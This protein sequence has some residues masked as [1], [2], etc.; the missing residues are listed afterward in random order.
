MN[1]NAIQEI[2]DRQ[3]ITDGLHWYTR[4]V[5]LNRVD[6]QVQIFTE[7][8][9]ITFYGED[10]WTVGRDNIEAM[11]VPAVAKYTATH[12][13]ISNIEIDFEGPN[14][15]RSVCYLQAWHRPAD[16]SE[17]YTLRAQYHDK[18]S[19]TPVGWRLSERRLKAAGVS[20]RG[21]GPN[22]ESIGRES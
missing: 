6:K 12:H 20:N 17:D 18:W 8:G 10:G 11:L 22:M 19:R 3:E 14:D 9:R 5:D 15:A 1:D 4:W 2:I 13:Y 16:G 7:D 21:S